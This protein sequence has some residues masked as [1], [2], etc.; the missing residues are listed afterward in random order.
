MA[1][2]AIKAIHDKPNVSVGLKA[3]KCWK[4]SRLE[5]INSCS[6]SHFY[7]YLVRRLYIFFIFNLIQITIAVK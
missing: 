1:F 7:V 3:I 6:H 5:L 4:A 2:E